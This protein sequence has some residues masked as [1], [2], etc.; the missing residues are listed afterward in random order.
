MR[1]RQ[2]LDDTARTAICQ[3]NDRKYAACIEE[4]YGRYRILVYGFVF[5]EKEVLIKGGWPREYL[6]L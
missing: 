4:K 1:A 5:R 6:R 3:I 2:T